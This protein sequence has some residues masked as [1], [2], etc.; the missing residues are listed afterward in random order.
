MVSSCTLKT[1]DYEK[2]N[3]YTDNA[4]TSTYS[5]DSGKTTTPSQ[6]VVDGT[7]AS[8]A[9]QRR[10]SS[11]LT[12][13][14]TQTS[15]TPSEAP[16]HVQLGLTR[17]EAALMPS[18]FLA[19]PRNYEHGGFPKKFPVTAS[20]NGNAAGRS[21]SQDWQ[22]RS[23]LRAV[24]TPQLDYQAP[25]LPA[26]VYTGPVPRPLPH[27]PRTQ[28][29][30]PSSRLASSETPVWHGS[31]TPSGTP[32]K[33]GR[34]APSS[35]IGRFPSDSKISQSSHVRISPKSA[36]QNG[37]T[38]EGRWQTVGNDD[39]H[40]VKH[41]FKQA[42]PKSHVTSSGSPSSA[43]GKD[44]AAAATAA[45]QPFHRSRGIK[46]LDCANIGR[47][48]HENFEVC[49]CVKCEALSRTVAVSLHVPLGNAGGD[50]PRFGEDAKAKL[51][52]I[53]ARFG[54]IDD[55]DIYPSRETCDVR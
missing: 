44:K 17:A 45:V 8:A 10:N 1:D 34:V 41:T 27:P 53:F 55:I 20:H 50:F 3:S 38:V 43:R 22:N 12:E 54:E 31:S 51:H 18:T 26:T 25:T 29:V 13:F 33:D 35:A 32:P 36:G 5:S 21:G 4:T 15:L 23:S 40:G 9:L 39:L 30:H 2:A 24:T 28:K 7:S 47:G 6:L 46:Y 16:A 37:K 48:M 42:R 52:G 19:L 14:A 49:Q 11:W